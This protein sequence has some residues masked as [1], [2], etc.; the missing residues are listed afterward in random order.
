MTLLG[1]YPVILV[2]IPGFLEVV[3]TTGSIT[4]KFVSVGSLL[5]IILMVF[6]GTIEGSGG[7]YVRDDGLFK[8]AGLFQMPFR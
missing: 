6:L 2:T 4:I 7:N 1:E 3:V 5:V 8:D